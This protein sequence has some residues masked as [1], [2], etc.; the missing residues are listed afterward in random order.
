MD[1]LLQ[2]VPIFRSAIVAAFGP[3]HAEVDPALRPSEFADFQANVALGLKKRLNS[4]PRDIATAIIAKLEALLAD[5]AD[6]F[7]ECSCDD[8]L[9]NIENPYISEWVLALNVASI[10]TG[11]AVISH[12][13]PERML[14][15]HA[16]GLLT[17]ALEHAMED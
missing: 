10:E 13:G 16:V 11:A 3:E 5:H 8:P 9:H 14:R 15:S 17:F 12:I 4:N 1:P 2:L 7:G 6:I